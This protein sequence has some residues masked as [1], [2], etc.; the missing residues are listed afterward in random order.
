MADDVGHDDLP[1][2]AAALAA[3]E[4]IVLRAERNRRLVHLDIALEERSIG[5]R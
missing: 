2:L 4:G 3:G 5:T 1:D